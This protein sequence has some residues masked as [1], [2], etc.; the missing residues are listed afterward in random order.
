M[1]TKIHCNLSVNENSNVCFTYSK[2]LLLIAS[3]FVQQTVSFQIP[4]KNDMNGTNLLWN[5]RNTQTQNWFR[6]KHHF[7]M[8]WK[9]NMLFKSN[10]AQ[11]KTFLFFLA[12]LTW[13]VSK[14]TFSFTA[15][16][17]VNS[18]LVKLLVMIRPFSHKLHFICYIKKC[19]SSYVSNWP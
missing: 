18:E 17:E 13:N 5:S 9:Q 10:M 14:K 2:V 8:D 6:S 11:T 15:S 16:T 19:I 1:Q 12:S 4:P 3:V 7:Q